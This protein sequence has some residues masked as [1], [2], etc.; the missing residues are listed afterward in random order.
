VVSAIALD[1]QVGID[2]AV[3]VEAVASNLNDVV[4]PLPPDFVSTASLL[5]DL[6]ATQ[7]QEGTVSSLVARGRAS[8]PATPE[9]ILPS[10]LYNPA[11]VYATPSETEWRFTKA[12]AARQYRLSEGF[13]GRLLAH[14]PMTLKCDGVKP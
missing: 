3:S 1:S 10:R 6:C 4:S 11:H 14:R 5:R 8:V 13:S 12:L 7:L 9:G 2:G